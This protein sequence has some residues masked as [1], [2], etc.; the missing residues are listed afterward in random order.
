MT[1]LRS[2]SAW[3]IPL[4]PYI[5]ANIWPGFHADQRINFGADAIV[6]KVGGTALEIGGGLVAKLSESTSLFATA[7]YTTN[8]GGDKTQ[9]LEGNIGISIKW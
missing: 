1:V 6:T 4:Q 9:V 2:A 5:K 7:D 8:L 3:P